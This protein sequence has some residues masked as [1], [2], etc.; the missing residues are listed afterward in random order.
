MP[1]TILYQIIKP[2]RQIPVSLPKLH[3]NLLA[4]IINRHDDEPK[5]LWRTYLTKCAS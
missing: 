2:F 3:K 5:H 4:P 1:L